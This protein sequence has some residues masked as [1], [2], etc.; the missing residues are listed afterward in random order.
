MLF[1]NGMKLNFIHH[2]TSACN[3]DSM[4]LRSYR[5]LYNNLLCTTQENEF[6]YM[7]FIQMKVYNKGVHRLTTL[8]SL[9]Q[10]C[11]QAKDADSQFKTIAYKH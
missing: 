8:T 9:Q 2:N 5:L 7:S 6:T 11:S 4:L 10:R 1:D 3:L